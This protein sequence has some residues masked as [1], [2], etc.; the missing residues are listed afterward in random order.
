[1][2]LAFYILIKENCKDIEEICNLIIEINFYNVDKFDNRTWSSPNFQLFIS[3]HYKI[4]SYLKNGELRLDS[5][6]HSNPRQ[7]LYTDISKYSQ[8]QIVLNTKRGEGVLY[9]RIYK[10]G[11]VD[12]KRSWGDIEIPVKGTSDLLN[13]DH[14][15]HSVNFEKDHTRKCTYN[16]CLLLITYENTFSPSKNYDYLIP[17]TLSTRLYNEDKT[18]QSILEIP[19]KAY[20]F[21]AIEKRILTYNYFKVINL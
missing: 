5:V 8:G 1:M 12:S 10:K 11:T 4:P 19:L 20:A 6:A 21:G 14:F 16:G 13:Y 3:S 18:K 7:Y 15:T 2:K 17:F 9:V